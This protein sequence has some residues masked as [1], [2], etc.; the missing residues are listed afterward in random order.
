M[1]RQGCNIGHS[2][3][4]ELWRERGSFLRVA[5]VSVQGSWGIDTFSFIS[6][7]FRAILGEYTNSHVRFK[8]VQAA[9]GCS[10]Y[11]YMQ[12]LATERN[13][14]RRHRA[15]QC[16]GCQGHVGGELSVSTTRWEGDNHLSV[17]G[18]DRRERGGSFLQDLK[19]RRQGRR[20]RAAILKLV[21]QGKETSSD[22]NRS[23]DHADL[24]HTSQLR[25]T[26]KGTWQ[27]WIPHSTGAEG[28]GNWKRKL[29]LKPGESGDIWA[30]ETYVHIL[31]RANRS[32]LSS[33][34]ARPIFR[35]RCHLT[36]RCWRGLCS[37]AF[38]PRGL[39]VVAVTPRPLMM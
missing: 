21:P 37:P 11:E 16:K 34:H 33:H 15:P 8:W 9:G 39:P 26:G 18:T 3:T 24:F 29:S 38:C 10:A 5:P 13:T 36:P 23:G 22:Q 31:Q 20:M 12:V 32:T 25:C 4:G 28:F 30:T 2:S 7:G 1:H 17:T 6:L 27:D 35:N 14:H 19:V